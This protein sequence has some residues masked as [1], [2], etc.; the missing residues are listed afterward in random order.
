MCDTLYFY[1]LN[2]KHCNYKSRIG[3][4]ENKV[5]EITRKCKILFVFV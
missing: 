5:R 3:M 4:L 2:I 1:F